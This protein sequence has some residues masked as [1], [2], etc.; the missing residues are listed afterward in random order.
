MVGLAGAT[1]STG[2][3]EAEGDGRERYEVAEVED[4]TAVV[5]DDDPAEQDDSDSDGEVHDSPERSGGLLADDA[6][7]GVVVHNRSLSSVSG[8]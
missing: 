2:D 6:G 5:V 4:G 1:S 7:L 8:V 3:D